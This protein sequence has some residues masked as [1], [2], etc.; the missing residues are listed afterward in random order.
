MKNIKDQSEGLQY[1]EALKGLQDKLI[2]RAL[3]IM[4]AY[5]KCY[6]Y[7]DDFT[8]MVVYDDNS[9]SIIF[10]DRD[11]ENDSEN[12]SLQELDMSDE[13]FDLHIEKLTAK[14]YAAAEEIKIANAARI[15][16]GE[17]ALLD[18]LKAK[19]Q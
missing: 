10:H 11:G 7:K 14:A 17:R 6:Y 2:E 12:F 1:L 9:I 16:K 15:E 18:Q 13:E 8:G 5:G 4:N 19:Y 3:R